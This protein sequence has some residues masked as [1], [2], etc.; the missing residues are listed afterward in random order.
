MFL[1]TNRLT[2]WLSNS[3]M[4]RAIVSQT[5][6]KLLG[7]PDV[8]RSGGLGQNG[9]TPR[10]E[11]K[12]DKKENVDEWHDHQTF[13]IALEKFESWIFSRIVE[14]VWWQVKSIQT[15]IYSIF[16]HRFLSSFSIFVCCYE[17]LAQIHKSTHQA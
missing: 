7:G 8:D 11:E 2:F 3:I 6:G 1:S 13:L 14:S 4:L 12:N 10:R 9:L 5:V 15:Y 16:L 17:Y